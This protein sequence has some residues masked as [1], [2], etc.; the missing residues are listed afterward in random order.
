ML[1]KIPGRRANGTT[2]VVVVAYRAVA[3][4]AGRTAWRDAAAIVNDNSG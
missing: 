4:P 3:F 2:S 1:L